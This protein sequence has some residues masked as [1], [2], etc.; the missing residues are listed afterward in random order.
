MLKLLFLNCVS[1]VYIILYTA[2]SVTIFVRPT[3]IRPP[4]SP[5]IAVR[6]S[7]MQVRATIKLTIGWRPGK[8]GASYGVGTQW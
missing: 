3:A 8:F 4:A 5:A 7:K 1:T 2:F 6:H